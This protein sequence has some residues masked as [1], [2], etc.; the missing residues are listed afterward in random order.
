MIFDQSQ[1]VRKMAA[2]DFFSSL[3]S[4]SQVDAQDLSTCSG[5]SQGRGDYTLMFSFCHI[6]YLYFIPN[7]IS[8]QIKSA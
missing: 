4:V 5:A 3:F 8:K 1:D 7:C 6:S 2:V